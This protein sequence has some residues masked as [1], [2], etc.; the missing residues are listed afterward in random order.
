MAK[1]CFKIYY[2]QE[3]L[4]NT[5]LTFQSYK[6]DCPNP[7]H[8]PNLLKQDLN[9]ILAA[10]WQCGLYSAVAPKFYFIYL[11]FYLALLALLPLT[12][13]CSLLKMSISNFVGR[14]IVI[15]H[16]YCAFLF[17]TSRHNCFLFS[18]F[19]KQQLIFH[20]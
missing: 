9:S 14:Y 16:M 12:G 10:V 18:G 15:N 11:S 19:F 2:I 3:Q 5:T 17:F 20:L 6:T 1:F 13:H 7:N 4:Q 8:Y